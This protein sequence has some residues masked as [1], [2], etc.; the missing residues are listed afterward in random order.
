VPIQSLYDGLR[1][2]P[3]AH[4]AV[5]QLVEARRSAEALQ[6]DLWLFAVE[7]SSLLSTG[8]TVTQ[9]RLLV[10]AGYAEHAEEVIRR[11]AEVRSFR[12]ETRLAFG[13]RSCF[14]LTEAGA[15]FMG[16]LSVVPEEGSSTPAG[17]ANTPAAQ[18]R[19][20]EPSWDSCLRELR[21]GRRVVK[22]FTQ[23]APTQELILAAYEEMGWPSHLDDPL[24]PEDGMDPVR[25]LH[26]TIKRLN[27]HQKPHLIRFTG[28][29]TGHGIRWGWVQAS[30]GEAPGRPQG[31]RSNRE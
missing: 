20:K 7:L 24:P 21:V 28:D 11:T 9:L 16:S 10:L 14:V 26:D 3:S 5:A 4:K 25:R 1:L 15:A 12:P 22:R 8:F 6:T 2:N 13:P 29:G 19:R 31:G 23:P 18:V 27:R 17:N 30:R